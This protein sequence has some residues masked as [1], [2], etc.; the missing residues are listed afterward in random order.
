[1]SCC[2]DQFTALWL[3]STGEPASAFKRE[4]LYSHKG[5]PAFKRESLFTDARYSNFSFQKCIFI[6]AS[7]K[8]KQ[9][10]SVDLHSP[11]MP[12]HAKEGPRRERM[13]NELRRRF[14]CREE[15]P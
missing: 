1:M 10:S 8:H 11:K 4:Y 15:D 5:Q 2:K 13:V 9:L 7:K 3:R 12:F 14:Q 6:H